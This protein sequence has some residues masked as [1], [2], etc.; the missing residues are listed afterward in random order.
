VSPLQLVETEPQ[1]DCRVIEVDGELDLNIAFQLVRRLEDA[2]DVAI[3]L[4]DLRSCPFVDS[5]GLAAF[6][7]AQDA[8]KKSGTQFAIVGANDRVLRVLEMIGLSNKGLLFED[9][10]EALGVLI[11]Q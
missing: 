10:D 9:V 3:V 6:V 11:R 5:T 7:H 8:M 2:A 4:V 1:P